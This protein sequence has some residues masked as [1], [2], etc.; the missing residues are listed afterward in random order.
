MCLWLILCSILF[1]EGLNPF[2]AAILEPTAEKSEAKSTFDKVL[3][4]CIKVGCSATLALLCCSCGT[5]CIFRAWWTRPHGSCS[6]RCDGSPSRSWTCACPWPLGHDRAISASSGCARLHFHLFATSVEQVFPRREKWACL[7]LSKARRRSRVQL[8]VISLGSTATALTRC[9][10]TCSLM[11][12]MS[13]R[14]NVC[15]STQM[16]AQALIPPQPLACTIRLKKYSGCHLD[17]QWVK[18]VLFESQSLS[19]FKT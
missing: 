16:C 3:H 9:C 19:W 2:S 7:H 5:L 18:P 10:R 15:G 11:L 14:G 13:V 17:K 6:T 1:Q 8:I 4:L 12:L